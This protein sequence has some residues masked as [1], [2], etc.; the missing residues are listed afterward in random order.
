MFGF[1]SQQWHCARNQVFEVI[2]DQAKRCELISYSD[3]V[4]QID[5]IDLDMGSDKDRGALG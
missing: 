1:N 2:V 4:S 3:L 5:A